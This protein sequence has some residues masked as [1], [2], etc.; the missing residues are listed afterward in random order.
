MSLEVYDKN[1]DQTLYAFMTVAEHCIKY[2]TVDE[3]IKRGIDFT[4]EDVK[5]GLLKGVWLKNEPENEDISS[6][7]YFDVSMCWKYLG[8]KD[9]Q[10]IKEKDFNNMYLESVKNNEQNKK[11]RS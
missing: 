4:E 1:I 5:L 2:I 10:F 8:F 6:P 3:A 9:D 7:I 11:V